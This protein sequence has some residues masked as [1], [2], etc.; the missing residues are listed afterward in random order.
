MNEKIILNKNFIGAP[1]VLSSFEQH[2]LLA[3]LFATEQKYTFG[4]AMESATLPPF[5]EQASSVI[6]TIYQ[7]SEGMP[8]CHAFYHWLGQQCAGGEPDRDEGRVATL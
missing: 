6:G 4:A 8:E 2:P 1:I 7:E 3:L 5:R